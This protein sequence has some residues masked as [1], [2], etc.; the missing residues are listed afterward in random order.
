[1]E[2]PAGASPNP[3]S[4][5]YGTDGVVARLRRVVAAYGRA[6]PDAPRVGIADLSLPRGGFFGTNYGGSGHVG[7]QNGTEVDVL[8]PRKDGKERAADSLGDVDRRL[9]QDLLDRFLAAGA[10]HAVVDPRLG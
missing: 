10:Q 7:H 4:R 9:A 2:H 8:Y 1:M 5:R 6:H 3:R